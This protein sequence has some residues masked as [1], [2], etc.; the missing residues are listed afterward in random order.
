MILKRNGY[1]SDISISQL[2]DNPLKRIRYR[3]GI[4][5]MKFIMCCVPLTNCRLIPC[6]SSVNMAEMI[7]KF[8]DHIGWEPVLIN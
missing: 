6:A 2:I 5:L 7:C 8:V 4:V 3:S 1:K